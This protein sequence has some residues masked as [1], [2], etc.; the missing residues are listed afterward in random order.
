MSRLGLYQVE[1]VVVD[2]LH[3]M[4]RGMYLCPGSEVVEPLHFRSFRAAE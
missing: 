4:A 2:H 1:W 3:S